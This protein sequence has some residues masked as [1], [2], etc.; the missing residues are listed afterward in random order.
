ME[1]FSSV[2]EGVTDPRRSNAT[3]HSLHE[4]LMIA[5]LSTLCGGEGCADMERFGR[6]KEGFLRRFMELKHGIPSHDAFSDLFNA[7]DPDSL[8]KVLLRLLEDWAAVL[9]GDVIAIDGKSLRRSF[10]DAAAR[11]PVHLVQ[12]F[13]A[14]TR[15]VLGQVKVDDKSNEIAAMPKLLE[16]LALKG[17]IVTADAMHTQR[18]TAEAVT[19]RGGDHVL[20]LKGNQGSLYEDV[21]LYLDDPAQADKLQSCQ[22]VDGDHGRIE[23]R[24]AS[25]C[26]EIAWLRERHDWPGLAAI[27]KIQAR[28]ETARSTKTETRYYIM[29]APR[30]PERFQHAARA[31]WTIENC[32][33]WVLDVTMNE[34]RQRNRKDHGPENLA[35]IRRL[36]LNIARREPTKDAMRGKLK[37][38]AWNDDFLLN[39]IRAAA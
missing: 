2:F 16:M 37:R 11:S 28:R 14:G 32:L 18:A 4:M 31:H 27:G 36:A 17:G 30:A 6:A 23:T 12:A 3:R 15:L 22:H 25:V 5:L 34:D 10:A 33:H 8:Q 1:E 39:L 13:A 9:D 38:A 20:A 26:H 29:S 19:A 24:R 7:L 21:R 35:L